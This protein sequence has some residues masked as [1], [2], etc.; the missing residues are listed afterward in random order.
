MAEFIDPSEAFYTSFEPKQQHRFIFQID[1]IPTY[2]IKT[3]ARPSFESTE[4]ELPHLNVTRYV[5]G[6]T[7]W[8]G[9]VDLSLYDPISP[10]GSQI[11]M[12]W[13]RLSHESVTGRD[14][15]M[16]FHVRDCD[17]LVLGPAND[18]VEKWTYKGAWLKSADF[19]GMDWSSEGD[20]TEI[21]ITLQYNY[22]ILNY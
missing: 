9:S 10:S 1:G 7:K 4:I 21:T 12:E 11:V 13:A 14:G 5:K 18:I 3:A 16:D 19:G 6:K 22:A 8:G 20:V 15:Y 2:M 17:I